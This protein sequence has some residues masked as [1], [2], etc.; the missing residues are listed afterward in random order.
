MSVCSRRV[1]ISEKR[2]QI[3]TRV[4]IKHPVLSLFFYFTTNQS[5]TLAIF[6]R[7]AGGPN[8]RQPSIKVKGS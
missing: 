6:H 8:T 2:W 3:I 5:K 7:T 1:H 4:N